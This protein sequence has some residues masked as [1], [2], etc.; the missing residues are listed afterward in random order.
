MAGSRRICGQLRRVGLGGGLLIAVLAG[1]GPAATEAQ[2]AAAEPA[3]APTPTGGTGR[4]VAARGHFDAAMTHYRAHRYREAIHEFELSIAKIPNADVW[5]NIGRAHEQL[6]E[7]RLAV[8]S[9]RRYL[10][11]RGDAPDASELAAHI[12]ALSQRAEASAGREPRRAELGSLAIDAAQPGAVVQLDGQRLGLAPIDRILEIAPGAHR[13][14]ASMAGFVPFRARIE[15]QPGALSAAY[16]DLRPLTVREDRGRQ[17][18]WTW[19]TAGASV[20][21]LVASGTFGVLATTA[22]NHRDVA[23]EA[24]WARASDWALGGAL[25]FGVT[26]AI[27]HLATRDSESTGGTRVE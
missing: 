12:D 9:Y 13:L 2:V 25:V 27:V 1:A 26:A 5:F 6:G 21:G 23:A 10:R 8:E 14:E 4:A 24:D 3:Q 20:A 22:H 7:H 19:L 16:V 18:L 17:P 11:D 15:V